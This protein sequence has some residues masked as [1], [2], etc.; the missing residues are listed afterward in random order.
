MNRLQ[1]SSLALVSAFICSSAHAEG[2]NNAEAKLRENLRNTMLQLR[3]IQGERD[4][5]QVAKTE[6]DQKNKELSEKVEAVT[7]QLAADKDAADKSIAELK[8]KTADQ[9]AEIARLKESLEKWKHAQK[10]A[11]DTAAAK[12][13]E[14]AK[15]AAQAVELQR[16]VNDQQT[17]NLEMFKIGTEILGRYEKFGLGTAI[18]AREPFIGTMRVKLQNLVQDYSDKLAGQRIKP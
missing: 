15:L 9:D 18:T 3:T 7:K 17:K 14:R 6:A 13:A 12:E 1:L 8:A 5:L 11:A 4:T 16:K 10:K 2:P